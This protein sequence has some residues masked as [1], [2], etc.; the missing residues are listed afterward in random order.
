MSEEEKVHAKESL[1]SQVRRQSQERR[2]EADR[3]SAARRASDLAEIDRQLAAR[4]TPEHPRP[5]VGER[6]E[7][8]LDEDGES[9]KDQPA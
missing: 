2:A 5:V 9:I 6:A 4:K 3:R 8:D 1:F 7:D